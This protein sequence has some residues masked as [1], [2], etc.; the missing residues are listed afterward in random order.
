MG[1]TA[2]TSNALLTWFAEWGQLYYVGIQ[3][4]FW[5]A[6]AIAALMIAFQYKR[7]VS[8]KVGDTKAAKAA[9]AESEQELEAFVE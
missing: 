5:I 3:V 4:L 8:Y 9:V 6:I 7:F 2:T 1:T